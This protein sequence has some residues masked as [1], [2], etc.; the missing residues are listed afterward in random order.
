MSMCSSPPRLPTSAMLSITRGS[1]GGPAIAGPGASNRA[2]AM[3]RWPTLCLMDRSSR[4]GCGRGA[5]ARPRPSANSALDLHLDPAVY[6][7]LRARHVPELT[8]TIA[9]GIEP[10]GGHAGRLLQVIDD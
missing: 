4:S 7:V 5:R 8:F 1:S 6:R 10:F 3:A 2:A 9:L